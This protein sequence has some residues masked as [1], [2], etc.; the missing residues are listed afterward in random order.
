MTEIPGWKKIEKLT[1]GE[2]GGWWDD[3]SGFEST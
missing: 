1:V 3:Y 2:G